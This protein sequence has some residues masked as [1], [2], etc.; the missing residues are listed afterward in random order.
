MI[1]GLPLYLLNRCCAIHFILQKDLEPA[2]RG[3]TSSVISAPHQVAVLHGE[4]TSSA[5][6][7][8]L[9]LQ[10]RDVADAVRRTTDL[11]LP[12][13]SLFL[14]RMHPTVRT[15]RFVIR[16]K[17][18]NQLPICTTAF[19]RWY[20]NSTKYENNNTLL[21]LLRSRNTQKS[22]A[23]LHRCGKRVHEREATRLVCA[24]NNLS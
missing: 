5:E 3:A 15:I 16:G 21:H 10:R 17:S 4:Q 1:D 12:G 7:R 23:V 20:E 19:V 24:P 18:Q 6:P 14:V 8:R 2:A 13:S 11:L 9:L 22:E